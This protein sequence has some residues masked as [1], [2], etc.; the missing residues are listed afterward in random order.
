MNME[1]IDPA[2]TRHWND[3]VLGH[4][5][6]TS[7]HAH[8]WARVLNESYH[9]Q[10]QYGVLKDAK[11][12]VALL[13]LMEVSSL[14]TGRRGVSLPF[15]DE[16]VPLLSAGVSLNSVVEQALAIGR[17]RNWDYLEL[18]GGAEPMPGAIRSETFRMH[19]LSLQ[20]E[21]EAQFSR[22][23]DYQKRNIQ[24]ASREG[25]EVLRLETREAMDAFYAL[26]CLT[27]RRQGFPP[28]PRRFFH[29]IHKNVIA[30]G[31]G[32]LLL[33]RFEG[34]WI[35]GGVFL[36]FGSKGVYKFGASDFAFRHLC[37]NSLLI[38]EAIRRF[39][40]L[41][42]ME[43]SFGRTDPRNAGLLQFKRSWGGEETEM[44]YYRIGVRKSVRVKTGEGDE[45]YGFARKVMRKL[46][47]RILRLAGALAYQ[48]MG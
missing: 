27:R 29:A 32:F 15:S 24:K 5:K 48:H 23:R 14:V 1:F 47:I 17:R 34:R 3:W 43:L 30:Q 19:Y 2:S 4:E 7:F 21:E 38:W 8:E 6:A 10:A 39:R 12:V 25:V 20:G 16:C 13:P 36:H 45:E 40:E 18:R 31:G 44:Q 46:P 33:G 42:A 11:Q 37:A 28:Q 26:Q 35:A 41:G 9:Y 22:L